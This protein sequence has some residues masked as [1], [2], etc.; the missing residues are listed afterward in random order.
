MTNETLDQ[1]PQA[2]AAYMRQRAAASPSIARDVPGIIATEAIRALT[3]GV[4]QVPAAR[5]LAI[6]DALDLVDGD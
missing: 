1:G 6:L 4:D 3:Y 2:I 5:I